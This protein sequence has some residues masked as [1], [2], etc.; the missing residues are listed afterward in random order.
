MMKRNRMVGLQLPHFAPEPAGLGQLTL[1]GRSQCGLCQRF[2]GVL[3]LP[4][5]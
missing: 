5:A 3:H 4:P 1:L 2:Y